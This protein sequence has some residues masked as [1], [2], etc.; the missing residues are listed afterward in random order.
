MSN[1]RQATVDLPTTINATNAEAAVTRTQNSDQVAESNSVSGADPSAATQGAVRPEAHGT[2]SYLTPGADDT[3]TLP[4]GLDLENAD[5]RVEGANLV[6]VLAD[7]SELVI[8]GGAANIP[9]F[10]IGDI[11]LPQAAVLAALESSNINVAA[12]P[13]GYSASARAPDSSADFDDSQ[14]QGG[15]EDFA[16]ASLLDGTAFTDGIPAERP[17]F[18]SDGRPSI[19][20]MTDPIPFDESVIADRDEG[21]QT[22]SGILGFNPGSDRGTI[23][24]IGFLGATNVDEDGMGGDA[25]QVLTSGNLPITI[26]TYPAPADA[27]VLSYVALRAIDS[28]G[29]TVFTVTIDN[30]LTGAFTFELSGKLDHPDSD[31][32]SGQIDLDDII[33]L[34]FTYTVTD[35]DGDS[36]TST[37]KIDVRDDG[38][39]IKNPASAKLDEEDL[40]SVAGNPDD[41]Y[42]G[43]DLEGQPGMDSGKGRTVSASLGIDWGADDNSGKTG[44]LSFVGYEPDVVIDETSGEPVEQ[45]EYRPVFVNSE[46]P[47]TSGDQP[48]FYFVTEI[49]G[50]PALVGFTG[51]DPSSEE[52]WVFTVTLDNSGSAATYHFTLLQPIDHGGTDVEDDLRFDFNFRATDSDGDSANG[53]FSVTVNDDAPT[54]NPETGA[55]ESLVDAAQG[56]AGTDGA[57][58]GDVAGRFV[59]GDAGQLFS[60][61]ADGFGSVTISKGSFS[62]IWQPEEGT[63]RTETVTWGEGKTGTDGSTVFVATGTDSHQ[64]AAILTINP[65]GSYRFEMSAAYA[66]DEDSDN[67]S[68][69]IGFTVADKDGDTAYGELW[70]HVKD[71]APLATE[72]VLFAKM[73]EGG[74]VSG[75]L[76]RIVSFGA[77]GV[78]GYIVEDSNLSG[79]LTSLTSNGQPLSYS[80][81]D[82]TLYAQVG[83]TVIFTFTVDATTGAYSFKQFGA[84]DHVL[85]EKDASGNDGEGQGPISP[86]IVEGELS[87]TPTNKLT[88][89]LA[90]AVTVRDGDGDMLPLADRLQI[91]IS[92]SDPS[93]SPVKPSILSEDGPWSVTADTGVDFG[94]DN[95]PGRELALG[96]DV[97]ATDHNGAVVSLTSDNQIVHIALVGSILIGYIGDTAPKDLTDENSVFSVSV[98]A[99]TG[100]YVFELYR[101]LDHSAP[102]SGSQYLELT[103]PVEATDA[104]LDRTSGTITVRIDASGQID[105]TSITYETLETGVYAN[106]GATSA[107]R[108]GHV[109]AADTAMDGDGGKTI[110]ADT[111]AGI[112]DVEGGKAD[113]ILI[114]SDEANRLKGGAGNDLLV[115]GKGAD[116]LDGGSG[117]DTLIV[118]AD[119][120][121]TTGTRTITRGDGSTILIP[122]S[123]RSGESDALLGGTGN[124]TV[125]FEAQSEGQGFVFDRVDSGLELSGVETFVG[126][127]GDDVI[128]LPKGYTTSDAPFIEIQGGR[129]NDTLQ[130]S[131]S[132]ADR[133]DGGADDDLISGLGGNDELHGGTGNDQIWGGSG[134]DRIFGG[135]GDDTLYGNAGDD[136]IDAGAGDDS[137]VYAVG[138]GRDI[139]DGGTEGAGGHDLLTIEGASAKEDY[140]IWTRAAYN[141]A[142]GGGYHG[143]SE[144]LVTINGSIVAEVNEI[145]DIAIHGNG[146]ADTYSVIGD[147][148]DT[149]L[150]PSTISLSGSESA[151]SFNVSGLKSGHSVVIKAGGGDDSL[152]VDEAKGDIR[153]QDVK[154][155]KDAATGEFSLSLPNGAIIKATGVESFQFSN[156]TVAAA[157]LVEQAPENVTSTSLTV[158]ENS[159]GGTV[160]GRV[161]GVDANG[162]IDPLTYAFVTDGKTSLI[163]ADGRF[164]IDATTGVISVAANASIDYETTPSVA[165][166]IRVTD[167]LGQFID[168]SFKVDVE[169]VNEAPE[170]ANVSAEGTED[171]LIEVTL[172]SQDTDGDQAGYVI[173]SL[174]GN[175]QLYLSASSSDP[176][177]VGDVV[178]G[179]TVYFKPTADYAGV[180]T[181]TYAA[182]DAGGLEDKTPATA[183]VTVS[184][185]PD[186][187]TFTL[188]PALGAEDQPIALDFSALS[189]DEDGSEKLVLTL[190]TIP[191]GTTILDDAGHSFTSKSLEDIVDVSNWDLDSLQVLPPANLDKQF[192]FY[193][194]LGY[195]DAFDGSS[196]LIKSYWLVTV[197]G[198]ADTPTATVSPAVGSEDEK[199]SL[200][201]E[202]HLSDT[203]GS[204]TLHYTISNIPAGTMLVDGKG[205]AAYDMSSVDI[206]KWDLSTLAL[207]PAYNYSGSFNL[208][209]T[210]T[211]EETKSGD[212]ASTT[213]E[214]PVTVEAVADIPAY[215]Q[216]VVS[217]TSEDNTAR[218]QFDAKLMD[219]DGSETLSLLISSI[220][221][222]TTI[223][224]S[225]NHEFTA[226]EGNTQVDVTN[227][228]H[229]SLSVL[230]PANFSG[231]LKLDL[232]MV[233]TET[234]NGD[235]KSTTLPIKI[236]VTSVNDSAEI[237]GDTSGTVLEATTSDDGRP[238]ATGDLNASDV[239]NENDKWTAVLSK[240]ASIQGYGTFTVDANG[241]WIYELDNTNKTVNGLGS[242]ESLTDTFKVF[243]VDGTEQLVTVTI[244][245]ADDPVPPTFI[246][247]TLAY[248]YYF[249]RDNYRSDFGTSRTFVASDALDIPN[250]NANHFSVDVQDTKIVV[251]FNKSVN[252]DWASFNG[253]IISDNVDNL[254]T[255]TGISDDSNKA[256][257]WHEANKIYVT[258]Q[259]QSFS[260]GETVTINVTFGPEGSDPIVLDLD[261]NGFALSSIDSGVSFDI[262]ADGIADKIAWTSHD[263]ILAYDLNGNGKIDDGS[264]IFTPDFNGGKF[265]SGVEAL[266]SLD[267]N[268][269]GRIDAGDAAFS[270]LKIWLDA[271]N[272]GISDEGELSSLTAHAVTSISL[273]TDQTGGTEDGQVV[274]SEGEFTFA[275]GSTGS[276][277]E[278]GFDTIFGSASSDSLTLVGTDGNDRLYGGM[279]VVSLT[280]GAGADT[281]VFDETA[282]SN[283]DVADVITDYNLSEGDAL[284]VSALLDTLLGEQTSEAEAA[285][286]MKLTSNGTDTTLSVD[287]GDTG[288]KD[289][290]VLQNHTEAVKIL[291]DD[292]HLVVDT[293]TV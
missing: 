279:E 18:G 143:V 98:D 86:E 62:V 14:I 61:G 260:A 126:T 234:S 50:Q 216:V 235:T 141:A 63:A 135:D 158:K 83:D 68:I 118:S 87:G 161:S 121:D 191:V 206:T 23:S 241:K 77:D 1:Q 219:T 193:V 201:I 94:I 97:V 115:D 233:A 155:V 125:Y 187:F 7:G 120:A 228:N 34:G 236:G 293:H 33:S 110:G 266:A 138:D 43:G 42:D 178:T 282:L 152:V 273:T 283:L 159:D 250:A 132:Q 21:N 142:H 245:G 186:D 12:G 17:S 46:V 139:I 90:T 24:A 170:T 22:Y 119:M 220:P 88:L 173:K 19:I 242:H 213:I 49:D 27:S 104:D 147:F 9:T 153:W 30:R 95:G 44:A 208:I 111:I 274:F 276:F 227:W 54:A 166:E 215:T 224:D 292:K 157:Q 28:E 60:A 271:N 59:S 29:H 65:D 91:T 225:N 280:G 253:F 205:H 218:L 58:D 270:D 124:D 154:V 254:K 175:G 113:D 262:N 212:T 255:I 252:W 258:W 105:G 45:L 165:L 251:T 11:E 35:R 3:V 39:T 185:V 182:S 100:E 137:I 25:P 214:L 272:N 67:G 41:S 179:T 136:I 221:V 151:E 82:N 71:D 99:S 183:T 290:A 146:G 20:A 287:L 223:R 109:I 281:F 133:I 103:L 57:T 150:L 194:E 189:K 130:G 32:E 66:H 127:S 268:G 184:S 177:K 196:H 15:P 38:P 284:D 69:N 78:G 128:L 80:V 285:Q 48:V 288:W 16:M 73:A 93:F 122:I 197:T 246:G 200:S 167:S 190:N 145:E 56:A 238:T 209:V 116:T 89:D 259:G 204:E 171:G 51:S 102:T 55:S 265:A 263:G 76:S 239:D 114:G 256:T 47:L 222:G 230:P 168:K 278:V 92:D 198:V 248:Q 52:S 269:D 181:F 275:D 123:G 131:D 79:S 8:T 13:D 210:V 247:K 4:A 31:L 10:V 291:F 112:V 64:T 176:L 244:N 240:T 174:P 164:V 267:T 286:H 106:L 160:V 134:N 6:I 81:V 172:S 169:N 264:E 156:G 2:V 107:T 140:V 75:D 144:I 202:G 277:I 162:D 217:G 232:V 53:R 26:E 74:E 195:R 70:L 207:R 180:D 188:S 226:T 5:F 36:A 149:S 257:T 96:E 229:N 243:T 249:E 40:P 148:T 108:D 231:E 199:I 261:H 163:S 37:F 203:D 101:P 129:G 237:S 289:L 72:T 85:P 84:I 117:N 211:S 192:V